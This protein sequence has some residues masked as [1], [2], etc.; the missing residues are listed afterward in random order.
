MRFY[1]AAMAV[2]ESV[3]LAFLQKHYGGCYFLASSVYC[4]FGYLLNS[5]FQYLHQALKFQFF[6]SPWFFPRGLTLSFLE[7]NVRASVHHICK[8]LTQWSSGL[9]ICFLLNGILF[10]NPRLRRKRAQLLSFVSASVEQLFFQHSWDTPAT[11]TIIRLVCPDKST[12]RLL[13][14]LIDVLAGLICNEPSDLDKEPKHEHDTNYAGMKSEHTELGKEDALAL[15]LQFGVQKVYVAPMP[16]NIIR[17]VLKT[18]QSG[19]EELSVPE[20]RGYHASPI[21]SI[22]L[23]PLLDGIGNIT[24][25]VVA[26]VQ[27]EPT[28]KQHAFLY[29]G[30]AFY[31]WLR[32]LQVP[33]SP[34]S[35]YVVQP[36]DIYRLS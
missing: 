3:F 30:R 35:R 7:A 27:G 36:M 10:L 16:Y 29:R 33:L 15:L 6:D 18:L 8:T 31:D 19:G 25:D 21:C 1:V 12:F 13:S 4:R 2:Y 14:Y 26:L 20:S 5:I 32:T 24:E 22:T 17:A 11:K 28:G 34:D 9:V 23:E